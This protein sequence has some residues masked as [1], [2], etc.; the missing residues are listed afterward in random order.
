MGRH[1]QKPP[2][3]AHGLTAGHY[4]PISRHFIKER[5]M[6]IE[7]AKVFQKLGVM[8]INDRTPTALL[9]RPPCGSRTGV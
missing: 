7:Q 3:R 2:V 9:W 1:G 5:M 8:G 4:A 6:Q